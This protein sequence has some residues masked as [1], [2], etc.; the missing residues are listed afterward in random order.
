MDTDELRIRIND[1]F[2]KI[3][4]FIRLTNSTLQKM[5]ETDTLIIDHLARI[6]EAIGDL[7][8]ELRLKK[9]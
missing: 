4:E 9:A 8:R 6:D 2:T 1:E 5:Q 3:Q 7:E